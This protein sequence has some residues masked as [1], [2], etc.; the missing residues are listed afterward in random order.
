MTLAL[1]RPLLLVLLSL[2]TPACAQQPAAA[3]AGAGNNSAQAAEPPVVNYS[4]RIVNTYPHDRNAFTQGLFYLN[5]NLYESTGQVGQS[6][7]RKVHFEDGRVLQS[8]PIPPGLFGEGI[9]NFGNEIVSITW[10]GGNGYRWDLGTLRQ[11]GQWH[12]EGEGWGL[13]QNGTDIIM[14]DGTSAIRFLDPVTLAERRRITVTIQGTELT[15]LNELEYVNGEIFAN[16]WQTPRIA[17]I[18]PNTGRV[19][20][21]IDLSGIANEN[22]TSR[23]AVLNG[24]AFDAQHNRLFVTG[25]LWPHLYEIQLVPAGR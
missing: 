14:S 24:I 2:A 11:T 19:T 5:G 8:V 21:V 3:P 23:D 16:I 4:Y 1:A 15:E 18:D 10:Q 13:T 25:K 9:V 17:R 22:T 7:I 20:G 6:T 12:Y